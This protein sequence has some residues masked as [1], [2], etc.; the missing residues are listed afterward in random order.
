MHAF[1]LTMISNGTAAQ[2]DG[3]LQ[4]TD[5]KEQQP[6]TF[7]AHEP[8]VHMCMAGEVPSTDESEEKLRARFLL[9]SSPVHLP[10]AISRS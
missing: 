7:M 2:I 10:Y 4:S 5:L 1:Q 3:G 8:F 9:P 6:G